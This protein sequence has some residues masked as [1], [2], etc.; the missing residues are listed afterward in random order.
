MCIM[1]VGY[2]LEGSGHYLRQVGVQIRKSCALK[3]CPLLGNR[4]LR[5]CPLRILRTEILPPLLSPHL[6]PKYINMLIYLKV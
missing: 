2:P 3:F 1:I 5:F 6:K 4:V